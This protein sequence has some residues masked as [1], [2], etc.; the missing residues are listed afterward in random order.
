MD[1]SPFWI[2]VVN[3]FSS[4]FC[5]IYTILKEYHHQTGMEY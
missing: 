5:Q 3:F 2:T 4:L 1:F